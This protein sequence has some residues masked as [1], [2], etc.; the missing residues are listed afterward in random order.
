M[1]TCYARSLAPTPLHAAPCLIKKGLVLPSLR[2]SKQAYTESYDVTVKHNRFVHVCSTGGVHFAYML[3]ANN[4]PTLAFDMD[5]GKKKKK[6]KNKSGKET[7]EPVTQRFRGYAMRVIIENNRS[8]WKR[9]LPPSEL[10]QPCN[11]IML[12]RD[13]ELLWHAIMEGVE[14]LENYKNVVTLHID[15]APVVVHPPFQLDTL[16]YFS[17]IEPQKAQGT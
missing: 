11:L 9:E 13:V 4:V 12:F 5:E 10:L 14:R 7:I 6:K 17:E 15:V 16:K 8:N 1:H 2:V 3:K